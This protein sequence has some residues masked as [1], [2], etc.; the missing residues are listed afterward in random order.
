MTAISVEYCRAVR[1]KVCS[2]P[3]LRGGEYS[4]F[5]VSSMLHHDQTLDN[6]W[7]TSKL[8]YASGVCVC[9]CVCVLETNELEN[10]PKFF[11]RFQSNK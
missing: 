2:N 9:V 7:S 11:F 1:G 4:L 5:A 10:T 8:N 3:I 6:R